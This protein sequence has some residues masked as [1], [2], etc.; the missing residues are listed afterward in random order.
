MACEFCSQ[1][2]YNRYL[3]EVTFICSQLHIK[4]QKSGSGKLNVIG[5]ANPTSKEVGHF[6][7]KPTYHVEVTFNSLEVSFAEPIVF[8]FTDPDFAENK[9]VPSKLR[10]LWTAFRRTR[11]SRWHGRANPDSSAHTTFGRTA[12]IRT[13]LNL[14]FGQHVKG[15]QRI[16]IQGNVVFTKLSRQTYAARFQQPSGSAD[17]QFKR[18]GSFT[19]LA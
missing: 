12:V 1:L 13:L 6:Y 2:S 16:G 14:G 3:V 15:N 8:N 4:S 7:G 10:L 17:S 5:S 11:S 9:I 18:G 19:D